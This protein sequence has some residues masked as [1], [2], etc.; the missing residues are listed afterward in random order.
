MDFNDYGHIT[1]AWWMLER[2]ND[3]SNIPNRFADLMSEAIC[4][5][6]SQ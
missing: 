3:D 1:G 6:L 4:D 5:R 2:E